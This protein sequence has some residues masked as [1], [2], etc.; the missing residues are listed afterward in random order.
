MIK[1]GKFILIVAVLIGIS[2]NVF[3]RKAEVAASDSSNVLINVMFDEN[4][5]G[6]DARRAKSQE[7]ISDWMSSDIV[8]VF[9]RYAKKGFE[10]KNVGNSEK[11]KA[12]K[13]EYLLKVKIVEYNPGSKAARMIVGFGAGGVKLNVHYELFQ[14]DANSKAL[15][16]KDDGVFSGIE[17]TRAARKIDENIAK[18]VTSEILSGK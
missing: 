1:M 8:R 6:L 16:A 5:A 13:G 14:G 15:L 7:Q 2:G 3:A 10:A 12:D 11:F 17:W 9:A 18:A 4:T